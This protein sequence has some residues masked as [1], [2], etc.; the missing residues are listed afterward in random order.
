MVNWKGVIVMG[1]G[2]HNEWHKRQYKCV[3]CDDYAPSNKRI[4]KIIKNKI[5]KEIKMIL[6][7]RK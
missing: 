3:Y 6:Q 5:N 4:R 2:K 7:E 1:K